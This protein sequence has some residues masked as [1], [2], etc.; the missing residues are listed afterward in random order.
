MITR[1]ILQQLQILSK[2]YPIVTIT[3]PRQSGKTT[4]AKAAFPQKAY[5]N[6]ENPELRLLATEDPNQFFRNYPHGAIIDEVQRVPE[7]LSYLQVI[8]DQ[9]GNDGMF[10][11]TG[12]N[13]FDLMSSVNQSLAGR[14]ALCK[15][16]PFSLSEI[17]HNGDIDTLL[18]HGFYPRIYDKKLNPT[19]S[20]GDYFETYVERD[21]RQ[22]SEV[23]NLHLFRKFVKLCAGQIGQLL[24]LNNLAND[25]GITTRTVQHWLSILE[26][27]YIIYLLPPYHANIGKRLIK[28]PKLYFYDVGLA[29]YLL[30]IENIIHTKSHP[31]RGHL[32]ENMVIADVIKNRFNQVKKNNLFFY[33]DSNGN[34][35]DLLIPN[36]PTIVPVEIKSAE[37]YNTDFHKGL[38]SFSKAVPNVDKK[39]FIVYGGT[40]QRVVRNTHLI[41]I[42][43]LKELTN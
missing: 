35:V 37:T 32:F 40:D 39:L 2:Q 28:A 26:A 22:I 42:F 7:L 3:G 16:L 29:S 20:Y 25:T 10:I 43:S 41:N 1:A 27:S 19:Q 6:L 5:A 31:S 9:A 23:K 21:L 24:N 36:G 15:L 34:E 4:L 33:R 38:I 11:L 12:S 13:Q 18:Y 8:V 30:D 14:T 17:K